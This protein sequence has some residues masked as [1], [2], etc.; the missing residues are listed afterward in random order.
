MVKCEAVPDTR[1]LPMARDL[2]PS[3]QSITG[4]GR[5]ESVSRALMHR[6]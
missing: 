4:Q 6:I 3:P 2:E 5:P 1:F